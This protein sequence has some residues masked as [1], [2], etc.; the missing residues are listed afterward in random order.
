MITI[1]TPAYNRAHLLPR[2][3]QSLCRQTKKNFEWLIVDDGSTDNTESVCRQFMGEGFP[4]RYFHKENG[5]KQR[6]INYAVARAEG[7]WFIILDSDDYLTDN[8]IELVLPHLA[9]IADKPDFAGVMGLKQNINGGISGGER[10]Y[11]VLDTDMLSFRTKHGYRAESTEL[12][13][14]SVMR[15]FP[16]PEFEGEKFVQEAVV[17][18][19]IARRYKCRYINEVLQIIE[20]QP[21]GLSNSADELMRRNPCGALLYYREAFTYGNTLPYRYW[22]LGEYWLCYSYCKRRDE[23][24]FCPTSTMRLLRPLAYTYRAVRDIRRRLKAT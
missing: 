22:A 13:R 24:P 20:Y 7:E 1:F 8:A 11:E 12:M 4:V 17:W 10:R 15:E 21:E 16:F 14:T 5:G 3:Y 19:R 2:L 23:E 6:A 9:S 18:N